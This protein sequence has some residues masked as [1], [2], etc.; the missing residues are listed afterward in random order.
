MFVNI[1]LA[2]AGLKPDA[3]SIIGVGG[4]AGAVA[5]MHR[6]HIVGRVLLVYQH[7]VEPGTGKYLNDLH[8]R[9]GCEDSEGRRSGTQQ[10]SHTVEA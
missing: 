8:T 2:K 7:P 5:I 3:V 6:R 4:G 10:L 9:D 1:L